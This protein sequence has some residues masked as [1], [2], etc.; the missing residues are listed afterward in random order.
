[1]IYYPKIIQALEQKMYDQSVLM[2]SQ[3]I[4]TVQKV[5]ATK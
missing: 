3:L 4:T 1:M 5:V 2:P